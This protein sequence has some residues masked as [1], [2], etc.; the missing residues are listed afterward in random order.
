MNLFWNLTSGP[1]GVLRA[2]ART[3]VLTPSPGQLPEAPVQGGPRCPRSRATWV[4][5]LPTSISYRVLRI[6]ESVNVWRRPPKSL[7][8]TPV[9]CQIQV[10]FA[11]Q[12]R[13]FGSV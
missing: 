12:D 2:G 4:A 7:P 1:H 10:P 3:I 13:S 5:G 9:T 8:A 11:F 6:G